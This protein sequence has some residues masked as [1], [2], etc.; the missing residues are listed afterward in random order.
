LYFGFPEDGNLALGC[1]AISCV[2]YY[3]QL[4]YV[5]LFVNNDLITFDHTTV[6]WFGLVMMAQL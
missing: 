3:F 1:L 6:L 2:V 4:L 5:Q